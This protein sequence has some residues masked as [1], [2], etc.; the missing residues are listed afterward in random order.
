MLELLLNNISG[1]LNRQ[2]KLD[3]LCDALDEYTNDKQSL[4]AQLR[5]E[6]AFF[7]AFRKRASAKFIYRLAQSE[8]GPLEALKVFGRTS[9]AVS[10]DFTTHNMRLSRWLSY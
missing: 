6:A 10:C 8:W 4:A 2:R 5:L 9:V 1:F 7:K 3:D